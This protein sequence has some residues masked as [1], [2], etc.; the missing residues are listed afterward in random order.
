VYNDLYN[1]RCFGDS[2]YRGVIEQSI[3]TKLTNNINEIDSHLPL[4]EQEMRE[5]CVDVKSK[6]NHGPEE[7]FKINLFVEDIVEEQYK[8]RHSVERVSMTGYI[9]LG[10]GDYNKHPHTISIYNPISSAYNSGL[11]TS[12]QSTVCNERNV[13]TYGTPMTESSIHVSLLPGEFVIWS[14]C[15]EHSIEPQTGQMSRF[16]NVN[17]LH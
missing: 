12:N 7:E 16:I 13:S 4:V 15:Y 6:Q 17:I 1:I 9:L 14:N 8:I 10:M 11:Y 5:F 2:F 3:Y